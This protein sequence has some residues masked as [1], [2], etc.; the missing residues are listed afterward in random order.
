MGSTCIIKHFG[1][2]HWGSLLKFQLLLVAREHFC[3]IIK[4]YSPTMRLI[5]DTIRGLHLSPAFEP[6][7]KLDNS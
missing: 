2:H 5:A 3:C 1:R 4:H 7:L 6:C